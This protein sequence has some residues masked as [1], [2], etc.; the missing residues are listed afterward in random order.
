M[1]DP[2]TE[3]EVGG[4]RGVMKA[5]LGMPE[6]NMASSQFSDLT[7]DN[8]RERVA[9]RK[10]ELTR[11]HDVDVAVLADRIKLRRDALRALHR[12]GEVEDGVVGEFARIDIAVVATRRVQFV[13]DAVG[14]VL[15]LV[16]EEG[17]VESRLTIAASAS[18]RIL[19]V[20]IDNGQEASEVFDGKMM[21]LSRMESRESEERL[22]TR[23]GATML[24]K[25]LESNPESQAMLDESD[26]LVDNLLEGV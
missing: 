5:V 24:R 17:L 15:E 3:M 12:D 11:D 19:W 7:I 4:E 6:V 23:I 14:V 2:R 16:N 10:A 8:L 18:D 13:G 20:L 9:A 22:R 21:R 25:A 26:G 1:D